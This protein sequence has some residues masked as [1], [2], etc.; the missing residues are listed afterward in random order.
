MENREIERAIAE[1]FKIITVRKRRVQSHFQGK[2]KENATKKKTSPSV[3]KKGEGGRKKTERRRKK[4]EKGE[5]KRE[6]G[7]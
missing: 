1:N 5:K 3:W 2:Q 6:K 7:N 4:E